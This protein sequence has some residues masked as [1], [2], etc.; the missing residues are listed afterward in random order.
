MS[1][2]LGKNRILGNC[3]CCGGSDLV[4][5]P[6]IIMPFVADR[7][8]G[9]PPALIDESWGLNTVPYGY[10]HSICNT[11]GCLDCGFMFQD[12]RFSDAQMASLY[13]DYRGAEYTN[14][15]EKYEP[16]Y[17]ER[18]ISLNHGISFHAEVESF[19]RPHLGLPINIL[20][21]GGDT[22]INTPFAAE[23][24]KLHIYDISN[25]SVIDGAKAVDLEEIA[26]NHY[27]L[28]VCS[29][30][31]EHV[32]YPEEILIKISEIMGPDTVLYV[33]LP[34]E[35]IMLNSENIKDIV[36][37]KRHWH[38]HINFYSQNSLTALLDRSGFDILD[39]KVS[40]VM[41]NE[42]NTNIYQLA[43]KISYDR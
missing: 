15:R 25:K 9:Y 20:D 31:L 29:H 42:Q 10:A 32:P 26:R 8:L 18:N 16:G 1:K 33:E 5:S 2:S 24:S 35:K 11:L 41:Q 36:R 40:G 22:G 6:A 7:A 37:K 30:V 12:L 38:E 28:V 14:L 21:W 3:L 27:S 34:A 17:R 23:R 4:K 19:L 13:D 43:A 39:F